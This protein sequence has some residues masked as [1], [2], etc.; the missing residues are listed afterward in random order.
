MFFVSFCCYLNYFFFFLLQCNLI[1]KTLDQPQQLFADNKL[2]WVSFSLKILSRKDSSAPLLGLLR[3]SPPLPHSLYGRTYGRTDGR[4]DVRTYGDVIT[5]FSRLD[6]LPIFLTHGA[7][8]ARLARG[9]SAN[10]EPSKS[11]SWKV[12]ETVMSHLNLRTVY[13]FIKHEGNKQFLS[14]MYYLCL[15]GYK[16]LVISWMVFKIMTSFI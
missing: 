8:L 15:H 7:S 13:R 12:L 14:Y 4:T 2:K 5:K 1:L 9:S 16:L 6:G 10:K 11:T 3:D